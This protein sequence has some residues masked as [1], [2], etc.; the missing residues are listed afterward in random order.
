MNSDK[1]VIS[2]NTDW[3]SKNRIKKGKQWELK[4][5]ADYAIMILTEEQNVSKSKQKLMRG[6]LCYYRSIGSDTFVPNYNKTMIKRRN[7][8]ESYEN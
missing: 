3:E 7:H 5:I 8:H 6:Y 1:N 4:Y 2:K